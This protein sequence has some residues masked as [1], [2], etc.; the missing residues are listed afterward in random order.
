VLAAGRCSVREAVG[1]GWGS[2]C[3]AGR[4]AFETGFAGVRNELCL[5]VRPFGA[6]LAES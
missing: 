4:L 5:M 3:F 6:L 1:C 2:V